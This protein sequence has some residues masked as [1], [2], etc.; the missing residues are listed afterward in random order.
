VKKRLVFD[1]VIFKGGSVSWKGQLPRHRMQTY[2]G[3]Y[4]PGCRADVLET[5][6]SAITWWAALRFDGFQ[7]GR[8]AAGALFVDSCTNIEYYMF[9]NELEVL[10][11]DGIDLRNV[12]APWRFV[13]RGTSFGIAWDREFTGGQLTKETSHV[14]ESRAAPEGSEDYRR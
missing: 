3:E 9:L 7:R 10:I 11:A 8:S 14:D 4:W 12:C 2:S 1:V 13:K 6:S 5:R